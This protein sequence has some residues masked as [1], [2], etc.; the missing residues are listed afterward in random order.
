MPAAS[1]H[2]V[3]VAWAGAPDLLA[4]LADGSDEHRAALRFRF[5]E[6]GPQAAA[7]P[8][9]EGWTPTYFV[10]IVQAYAGP[11]G[12]LLWDGASRVTLPRE[13]PI[14]AE[15]AA[16]EGSDGSTAAMMQ[17]ALTQALRGHRLFH[18]HAAGLELPSGARVLVVGSQGAGKTTT[19]LSLLEGSARTR[20]LADDAMF[21]A[22]ADGDEAPVIAAA[23]P[24]EFH[25]GEATL[26]AFPRLAALAGSPTARRG[27]R[28]V[29][30]RR[31]YPGRALA[32]MPLDRV[33]ALFPVIAGAART[34]IEPRPRADAFGDLLAS[35][36]SLVIEGLPGREENLAILTA[37]LAAS[38]CFELRLGRDALADPVGALYARVAEIPA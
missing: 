11:R 4:P 20:Y 19:T 8:R 30:A 32:A 16:R 28:P 38:R 17:M 21:L 31:A 13:G 5:G 14:E 25:L 34:E 23:F 10:G 22:R 7:D 3:T 18:L 2:G 1:I 36:A 35:S 37:I 9:G 33:I 15:I 6:A 27:K 12:A 24:R 26:G 29:D